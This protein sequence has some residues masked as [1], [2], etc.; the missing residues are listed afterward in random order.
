[1]TVDAA[2]ATKKCGVAVKCATI[3]PNAQRMEEYQLHEMEAPNGTIRAILDGT[4][5]R[6]PIMV[7]GISPVVK[8]EEAHHHCP[9]RLRRRIQVH[10][11]PGP[12]PLAGPSW[13]STGEGWA[14]AVPDHLRL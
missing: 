3:T 12:W 8:P 4:A 11:V 10:R 7:K 1:M 9:S 13:S 14:G 5:F 6:A 2:E